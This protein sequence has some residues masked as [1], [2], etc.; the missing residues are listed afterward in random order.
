MTRRELSDWLSPVLVKEMRQG[1]KSRMF[2]AAFLIV[3]AIMLCVF[4]VVLSQDTGQEMRESSTVMFWGFTV[5]MLAVVMPAMALNSLATELK[6]KTFDLVL[7][8]RLTPWRIVSGKWAS[9][10]GQ[11]LLVATGLLPYLVL[12]YYL[13][14]VNLLVE[15]VLLPLLVLVAAA[16]TALIVYASTYQS[17][18]AR[19]GVL[20]VQ[21]MVFIAAVGTVSTIARGGLPGA[22]G[23]GLAGLEVLV[24]LAGVVAC[25]VLI[26]RAAATRI[27]PPAENHAAVKRGLA[28]LL[29]LL[30]LV[31]MQSDLREVYVVALGVVVGLVGLDA[32]SEP[33]SA[34]PSAYLPYARWPAPGLKALL[35]PGW[36]GGL[37]FLA[38]L[39][40][41]VAVRAVVLDGVSA[42]DAAMAYLAAVAAVVVP[43]GLS[44][45]DASGR[46]SVIGWS[47]GFHAVTLPVA[48][49]AG[50]VAEGLGGDDETAAAIVAPLAGVVLSVGQ[51]LSGHETTVL[52]GMLAW[53]AFGALLLWG[54]GAAEVTVVSRTA[55]RARA[56]G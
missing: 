10:V 43:L 4:L 35:Y 2:T 5:V 23:S 51:E 21:G 49:V 29:F 17:A 40:A 18:L 19:L 1:L 37:A 16:L 53:L 3:Q 34:S 45:L 42:S 52:V 7:L 15:L 30:G 8:T 22:G 56:E 26:L 39:A 25:V 14:G 32:C 20:A 48:M 33:I 24:F 54:R 38:V 55:A 27:A 50:R 28:A 6:D 46:R 31:P 47:V 41:L 11:I 13:G 12:R 44:R 36:P 9:V